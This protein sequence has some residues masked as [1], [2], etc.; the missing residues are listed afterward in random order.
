MKSPYCC[1]QLNFSGG[2]LVRLSKSAVL[3]CHVFVTDMSS[4][5]C[6]PGGFA[7]AARLSKTGGMCSGCR[8]WRGTMI[9]RSICD[10]CLEFTGAAK[11]K[12]GARHGCPLKNQP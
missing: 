9:P 8:I 4:F 12:T 11:N 5:F 10:V 2:K 3:T 7:Y 6:R 1:E